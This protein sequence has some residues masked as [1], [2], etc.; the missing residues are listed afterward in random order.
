MKNNKVKKIG[1]DAR[2][3]GPVGK[4][5][6]RYTKELIDNLLEIDKENDYV[7][8]LGKDN[9]DSFKTDNPRTKKV[10]ADVRWYT[11]AEQILMPF[12]IWRERIDLMHFHHFNVPIFCPTKFIVTI[13]DLILIKFPSLRASKLSPFLYKIKNVAYKFVLNFAIKRSKKIIAV[14]EFTKKDILENFSVSQDKI[15]V[16]YEGVSNR[17]LESK[18]KTKNI[19]DILCLYDIENKYLLYVGNAY[20]HKNLEWLIKV[21]Y[22]KINTL[23]VDLV[24]VG[25]ED[26]FYKRLKELKKE[27]EN[28]GNR[29]GRV[30]F[31]G[32]VPDSDL[33]FLFQGAFAYVFPSKYEG[34]GIP[35]LEAMANDCPVISSDRA[36][37]PEILGESAL[38]FNPENEDELFAL[39][40]KIVKDNDLRD[41]LIRSGREQIKKYSWIRCAEITKGVLELSL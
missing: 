3:Y 22:E 2:F 7:V 13:H 25:K 20:P 35:P 23:G 24:L 33:R 19:A 6:G 15:V 11:L 28:K 14:S 37:M 36:S 9:F 4:G 21:F 30:I 39:V 1:I 38:Y 26:Y 8:F 18:N 10:L 12:Y 34:F 40:N 5:L 31:P 17:L 16:T 29:Q 27:K 41:N 32:Y